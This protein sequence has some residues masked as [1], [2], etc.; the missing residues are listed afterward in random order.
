METNME[1][2]LLESRLRVEDLQKLQKLFLTA[3]DTEEAVRMG[4]AEF[5]E[6]AWSMVGRGSQ[7]EFG[8]LFDNVDV[9]REGWLDWPR[10]A[11]F[12][13]LELSEKE[14]H[15]RAAAV[16]RWR[17]PRMLPVPHRK[18]IQQIT[19]LP[20]SGSYLSLSKDAILGIW[21]DKLDLVKSLRLSNDSV[22]PKDLWATAMV[23]LPNVHKIA[24]AFS[25]KEVCFYDLLSKQEFNCQ[26]KVQGLNHTPVCL[27]YWSNP[28]DPDQAVLSIGDVGRVSALCFRS[29]Q[30]SLFE[31]P[32]SAVEQD[33][34]VVIRW[35]ELVRGRHWCCS[36]LTHKAH[37]QDWVRKVRFLPSLEAFLF[38]TTS[39]RTNLVMAWR[40]KDTSFLRVTQFHT[41]GRAICDLDFHPGLNIIATAGLNTHVCLWNPC[42]TSKPVGILSGHVTSV[43]AVQFIMGKK[44]LLSFSKDKVLRLWD[45]A[46]QLCVQCLASIFPKTQECQTRLFFHEESS[47]LLLSFN[48]QLV[49]LEARKETGRRLTSHEGPVTCVLYNALFRQVISSDTSSTV[50]CWLMDTGQ[51]VKQFVRCHGDAAVTTMALDE[52]KTRLFTAGADGVVKVWDFNGYCHHKLNAGRDRPVEIS[53]VLVLKRTVL[54]VGW[55]RI[56]TV[57]RLCDFSQFFVQP[58]EWKGGVQHRED[59][60]CAAFRAP[61]MLLT[62]SYDG[63]MVVWNNSTEYSLRKLLPN[64]QHDLKGISDT[65]EVRT[66]ATPQTCRQ[67]SPRLTPALPPAWQ[68]SSVA[69]HSVTRLFFLERSKGVITAGGADLVSCGGSGMVRFWN[70]VNNSLL[71]EFVAHQDA[72]C[73][74]MTVDG[75][76]RYLVTADL[77]GSVKVWDIEEYCVTPLEGVINQDPKLLSTLHPHINRV[78]HLETCV[79]GEQLFL[80]SASVDCSLVLSYL[81]GPTVGVF[82]QE[83]HWRVSRMVWNYQNE[84]LVTNQELVG[85]ENPSPSK[86]SPDIDPQICDDPD[87]TLTAEQELENDLL[88]KSIVG[89]GTLGDSSILGR[90]YDERRGLK[91]SSHRLTPTKGP[92]VGTFS[93]LSIAELETVTELEKPNLLTRPHLYFGKFW[94]SAT[95]MPRATEALNKAFEEKSLFFREEKEQMTQG[96]TGRRKPRAGASGALKVK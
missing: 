22:R 11:S 33:T 66:K 35:A 71:A 2:E 50:T 76:G 69:S 16:P 92:T 88:L 19:H 17:P 83:E 68:E 78:T 5:V 77:D 89:G 93:G 46:S 49:L 57:F 85:C 95:P 73:I 47:R 86:I 41:N 52:T 91:R 96:Q 14:E 9:S 3:A 38:C 7:E 56:I 20:S 6:K 82:G 12:L 29:A 48:R 58:S 40:E 55:E 72:G 44:Q 39:G 62:G 31:R 15:A 25:S 18:P 70:T 67:R 43:V 60:L 94:S 51:K 21:S 61:Q 75:S 74:I 90:G 26:Y 63:E 13:L 42:V 24:V 27:D 4:R 23:V 34:A 64:G 87:T 37:G 1:T 10:L 28:E 65:L 80:L 59:I 36:I 32:S 79:H 8:H 30:I 54:M 81:P 53:Q 45:V 84:G